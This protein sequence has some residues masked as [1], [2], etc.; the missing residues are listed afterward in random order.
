MITGSKE[1]IRDI[2]LTLVLETIISKGPI[3]RA[4]IS[5]TL[6]LTKA[7]ISAIVTDL[8]QKQL[9]IEVGS[10]NTH[11]GRKPILL[12]LN[13]DAGYVISI[14]VGVDTLSALRSNLTG[15]KCKLLQRP[16][17]TK[18]KEILIELTKL[19]EEIMLKEGETSYGLIGISLGIHGVVKNNHISFAPYYEL[20]KLDLANY[21]EDSFHTKVF[22]EN[23]ANLSVLGETAFMP[24]YN[25][26]ANISVHSGL[27]LGLLIDNNLYTGYSGYAGE[28]GH[29]IVDIDGKP[30]PCGNFGCL[31]Q[32]VSERVLLQEFKEAKKL[33]KVDFDLLASMYQTG[34]LEAV[35]IFQKFIKYMTICINNIL[36]SYNPDIVIINSAFTRFF[37]DITKE[38]EHSLNSRLNSVLHI[39]PSRLQDSSILIGGVCVAVK[40]FLGIHSLKL[41]TNNL[42]NNKELA[43][44]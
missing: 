15:N 4:A 11:L 22:L 13:A 21:L 31:E 42:I 27:G 29:T 9:I 41:E 19:I 33:D 38:I 34:D 8:I 44:F 43:P 18:N 2:N 25:S 12:S 32:Y 24:E 1:L 10:D 6:G 3:S 40:N 30:C 20:S 37:P 17:P 28:I 36:N 14:D 26:I 5:K 35:K 7:T 23:E 16:T 39:Y